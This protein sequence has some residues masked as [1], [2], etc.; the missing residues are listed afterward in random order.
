MGDSCDL[1]IVVIDN[2]TGSPTGDHL[3]GNAERFESPGDVPHAINV[4]MSRIPEPE[5]GS[6]FIRF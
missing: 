6:P 2:A 3:D 4:L 5:H 1:V